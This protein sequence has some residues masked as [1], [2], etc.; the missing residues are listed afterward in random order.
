MSMEWD[1]AQHR[2]GMSPNQ[3]DNLVMGRWMGAVPLGEYSRAF[4]L[5]SVP[6][7]LLEVADKVLFWTMARR[8]SVPA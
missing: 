3:A 5:V 4:R 1:R 8:N 2:L 7:T 6:A